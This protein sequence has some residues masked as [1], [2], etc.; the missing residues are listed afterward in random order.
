MFFDR[1]TRDLNFYR[2][3][4][5]YPHIMDGHYFDPVTLYTLNPESIKYI[6]PSITVAR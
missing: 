2:R 3:Y 5:H 4:E 6:P 1:F